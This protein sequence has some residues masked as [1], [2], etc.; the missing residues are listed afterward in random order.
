MLKQRK[1]NPIPADR[2]IVAV[3]P[4][5]EQLEGTFTFTVLDEA[6]NLYFMRGNNPMCILHFPREG[7][8]FYAS[9][10]EILFLSLTKL[11]LDTKNFNAIP[12]QQGDLLRID[13]HGRT[14]RSRF[15]DSRLRRTPCRYW[16]WEDEWCFPSC[17]H[18][19]IRPEEDYLEELKDMA[20][21]FGLDEEIVALLRKEGFSFAEIEEMLYEPGAMAKSLPLEMRWTKKLR[22]QRQSFA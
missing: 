6:N 7:F 4:K 12:I 18:E 14:A 3:L 15:E 13:R 17:G 9:K 16:E 21:Y 2:S 22:Y 5:A 19:K 8:F 11:G 10:H 20:D 1:G